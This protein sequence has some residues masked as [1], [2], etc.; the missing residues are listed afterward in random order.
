[1]LCNGAPAMVVPAG[2]VTRSLSRAGCVS[3]PSDELSRTCSTTDFRRLSGNQPAEVETCWPFT[4][5]DLEK[6]CHCLI[7]ADPNPEP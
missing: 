6:V 1:M 2:L 7:M 5:V 3:V 4:C